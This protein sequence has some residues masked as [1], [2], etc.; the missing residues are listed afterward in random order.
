MDFDQALGIGDAQHPDEMVVSSHVDVWDSARYGTTWVESALISPGS[1]HALLRALQTVREPNDFR[2]PKESVPELDDMTIDKPGFELRGWLRDDYEREHLEEHDPLARDVRQGFT[3][4]GS[5]FGDTMGASTALWS[6]SCSL[7]DG[8][9]LAHT[10]QWSD[11]PKTEYISE[12]FS[13]Q[14]PLGTPGR[15][16]RVP[17]AE[18]I[19]PHHRGENRAPPKRRRTWG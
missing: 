2:L 13:R 11:D 19:R 16:A 17:Q 3:T 8:A 5:D 9:V 6:P 7:P 18:A 4:V 15:A 10:E 14:V 1:A 12:P